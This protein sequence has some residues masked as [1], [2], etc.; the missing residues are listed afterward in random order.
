MILA[1]TL[2]TIIDTYKII[3]EQQHKRNCP[4][5]KLNC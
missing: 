1:K 2:I 4:M 5:Y 3:T